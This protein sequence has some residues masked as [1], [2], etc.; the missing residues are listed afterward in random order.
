MMKK[1]ISEVLMKVGLEWAGKKMTY[2]LSGG[3]QQRVTIARALLNDPRILLADEPTGNLDPGVALDILNLFKDISRGGAA[4]LMATHN[5]NLLAKNST[6]V[7]RCHQG[8]F[9]DSQRVVE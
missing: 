7:F 1:K 8:T 2:Q 3:E 9:T 5:H 6:R 4:I